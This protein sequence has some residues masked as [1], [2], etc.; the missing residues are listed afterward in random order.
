MADHFL[1]EIPMGLI[2][3]FRRWMEKR[4]ARSAL[5]PDRQPARDRE[6]EETA[7]LIAIDII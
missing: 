4:P 7:E 1:R 6:D 2:D 5:R 3:L